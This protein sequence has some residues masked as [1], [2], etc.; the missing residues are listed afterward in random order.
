MFLK[1]FIILFILLMVYYGVQIAI[2]IYKDKLADESK[3]RAIEEEDVDITDEVGE[4][5]PVDVTREEKPKTRV[6]E[7]KEEDKPDYH[8]DNDTSMEESLL[9]EDT[10]V[11]LET[12]GRIPD[13]V[14]E[15][16]RKPYSDEGVEV[17]DLIKGVQNLAMKGKS[18]L[19]DIIYACEQAA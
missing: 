11:L 10:E 13:D 8:E 2:D 6:S 1:V 12:L 4:F 5:K 14:R 9:N 19:G 18:D 15:G 16:F 3:N 17:T 7:Q